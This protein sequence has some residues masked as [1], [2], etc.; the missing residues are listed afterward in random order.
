MYWYNKI[1][2]SDHN[3]IPKYLYLTFLIHHLVA[4]LHARH[5]ILPLN[6]CRNGLNTSTAIDT[7]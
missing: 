6:T 7:E 1:L 5:T 4:A 3:I 2:V